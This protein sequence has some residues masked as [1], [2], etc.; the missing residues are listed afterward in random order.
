M[1]R[2]SCDIL[3]SL[4]AVTVHAD[5]RKILESFSLDVSK[6]ESVALLGRNGSGKTTLLRTIAGLKRFSSG[7]I[8]LDGGIGMVFQNPESALFG[9][10]VEENL[11]FPLQSLQL[12]RNRI[13]ER[14]QQS[15]RKFGLTEI[16]DRDILTLSGGQRQLVSIAAALISEP[17]ILLLDEPLSMMDRQDRE[18]ILQTVSEIVG[19]ETSVLFATNRFSEVVGFDRFVIIGN[20]R[21]LFDGGI[22]ELKRTPSVFYE[23]GMSVPF[24]I[25]QSC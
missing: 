10:T 6:A 20:R 11:A 9:A 16:L 7:E 8:T 23:A 1:S 4:E 17:S 18:S 3:L 5:G 14:I 2:E 13:F 25:V 21:K 19:S 22:E 24:E 12:D 15:A